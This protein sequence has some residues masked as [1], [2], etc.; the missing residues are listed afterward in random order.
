MNIV[1][2]ICDST[3]PAGTLEK[4]AGPPRLCVLPAPHEIGI[5][6]AVIL[7]YRTHFLVLLLDTRLRIP[8]GGSNLGSR[9]ILSVKMFHKLTGNSCF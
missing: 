8:V 2:V 7:W 5:I 9:S 3:R 6:S 1:L 4:R